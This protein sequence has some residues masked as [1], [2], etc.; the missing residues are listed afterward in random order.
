[1]RVLVRILFSVTLT[2][3]LLVVG[4]TLVL[5]GWTDARYRGHVYT[6]ATVPPRRVALVFGA[7][8]WPDGT[9]SD[10]LADRVQVVLDPRGRS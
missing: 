8:V 1:M 5:R 10:I 3:L 4:G 9:L 2:A 7:G 6:V